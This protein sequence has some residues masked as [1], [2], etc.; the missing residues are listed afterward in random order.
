MCSV[1]A[2]IDMICRE[3]FCYLTGK[4]EDFNTVIYV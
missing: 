1:F 4:T 3:F 2:A